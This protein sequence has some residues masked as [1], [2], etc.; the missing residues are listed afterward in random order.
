MSEAVAEPEIIYDTL[1]PDAISDELAPVVDEL[2]LRENCRQLAMEGYTVV[3]NAASEEFNQRL[4]A[5]I[6]EILEYRRNR[7]GRFAAPTCCSRKT[8]CSRKRP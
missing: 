1:P 3:E 2:G 6:L 8:R 4:R 7:R 5:K